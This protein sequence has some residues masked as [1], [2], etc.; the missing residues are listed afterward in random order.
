MRKGSCDAAAELPCFVSVEM[1]VSEGSDLSYRA[2]QNC[3]EH[4]LAEKCLF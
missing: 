1:N 2:V 4:A 3:L